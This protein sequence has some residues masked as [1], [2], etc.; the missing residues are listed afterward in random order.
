MLSKRITKEYNEL[1]GKIES[2]KEKEICWNFKKHI[3]GLP[4]DLEVTPAPAWFCNQIPKDLCICSHLHI[5]P[6][7][8]S[9]FRRVPADQG[10]PRPSENS[11]PCQR[12]GLSQP[13]SKANRLCLKLR[14]QYEHKQI[15]QAAVSVWCSATNR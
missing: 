15:K 10:F 5:K 2:Q 11:T 6:L 1:H 13:V 8:S 12:E 14:V 9:R 4:S 3:K 7:S